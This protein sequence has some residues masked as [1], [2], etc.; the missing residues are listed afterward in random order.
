MRPTPKLF[1][2]FL[3]LILVACQ[4]NPDSGEKST[5]PPNIIYTIKG[6]VVLHDHAQSGELITAPN[7]GTIYYLNNKQERLVFHDE[8]TYL[9]WYKDVKAVKTIPLDT[10]EKYPLS[11]RNATIRPGT[12]LITI[13]SSPQVWLIGHPNTV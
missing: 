12:Y 8:Q 5:A 11:G 10:L 1:S 3:S 7:L 6:P 4:S 13:P 2:I 9:S